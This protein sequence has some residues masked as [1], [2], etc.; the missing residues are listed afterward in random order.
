[1]ANININTKVT[2]PDFIEVK[3]VREDEHRVRAT[4]RLI[5]ELL[6]TLTSIYSGMLLG[7]VDVHGLDLIIAGFSWSFTIVFGI[8]SYRFKIA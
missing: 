6:L 5:F 8:L 2:G 4:F 3:L 1:M 7:K